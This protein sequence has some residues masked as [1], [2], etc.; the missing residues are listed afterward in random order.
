ME[1]VISVHFYPLTQ[2]ID[3]LRD[4]ERLLI[5]ENVINKAWVTEAYSP[6]QTPIAYYQCVW[7]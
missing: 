7:W 3:K 4:F 2:G 6:L 1:L 5:N